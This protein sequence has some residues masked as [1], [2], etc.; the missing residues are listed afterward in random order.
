MTFDQVESFLAVARFGSFRDAAR[1]RG[2][3]QPAVSR[4]VQ[5]LEKSLNARLVVRKRSGCQL[6]PEA[7]EFLHYAETMIRLQLRARTF[8][9][10]RSVIVG[11]SSNIGTYLLPR[12]IRRFEETYP[13]V[14]VEVSIGTNEAIAQ[15]LDSGAVDI[16]LMEWWNE[17]PA[18]VAAVWRREPLVVIVPPE[19]AW[20]NRESIPGAWLFEEKMLGG[21]RGTG[22]GTLLREQFGDH[23]AVALRVT[24]QLG[25]TEAV[26][27]AV[28]HRLGVSLVMAA[29]VRDETANGALCSLR[30]EGMELTKRLFSVVRK[31]AAEQRGVAGFLAVLSEAGS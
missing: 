17:K 2:L 25:S 30:I 31:G 27:E 29:S 23:A 9:Q 5:A 28:K 8:L 13:K 26:K 12:L 24:R 11:A 22:T 1:Q 18:Y 3:S 19:H 14:G 4:Q 15:Q 21:E 7:R 6:T 16:A 20:A 10:P